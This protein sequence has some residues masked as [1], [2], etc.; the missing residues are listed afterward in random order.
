[1]TNNGATSPFEDSREGR[2]VL[3]E[4]DRRL[5]VDFVVRPANW[6]GVQKAAHRREGSRDTEVEVRSTRTLLQTS[7]ATRP[8]SPRE[9]CLLP[10][11]GKCLWRWPFRHWPGSGKRS[12][13]GRGAVKFL[14][15]A[16]HKTG[17]S[18]Q[19]AI[20]DFHVEKGHI[21][22][23]RA[24]AMIECALRRVRSPAR[25]FLH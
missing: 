2:P 8:V 19:R 21:S 12:C 17:L 5:G 16:S 7:H 25:G 10:R 24:V 3:Q 18:F 22:R 13:H 15:R 14:R 11:Y 23:C 4:T 1:M 6:A 20:S 9:G